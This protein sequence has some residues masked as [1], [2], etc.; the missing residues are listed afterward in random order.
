MTVH[1]LIRAADSF[2]AADRFSGAA[3]RWLRRAIQG[4]AA[5]VLRGAWLGHPVHPLLVTVPLGA[6]IG[7]AALDPWPHQRDAARRLVALGLA[8]VPPA[9][10]AGLADFP[11]LTTTQRRVAVLH[12]AT[13]TVGA[14]CFVASYRHRARGADRVGIAWTWLGLLGISAG[15][16][17]GGHLSYAL[18]AGVHRWQ[19][20]PV[21][22][23]GT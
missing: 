15:G 3:A 2:R 18:G 23:T 7:A 12:A 14:G 8:V 5:G 17:L 13:N 20:G 21:T 22:G 1:R 11:E 19:G 4:R 16:A 6:W 10:V 9:V